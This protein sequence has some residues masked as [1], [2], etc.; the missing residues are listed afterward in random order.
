MMTSLRADWGKQS[1]L[2]FAQTATL[3]TLQLCIPRNQVVCNGRRD[4]AD[5]GTQFIC[6]L[7][8]ARRAA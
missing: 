8:Q 2:V 4:A 6:L 3:C 5:D 1:T 7:P